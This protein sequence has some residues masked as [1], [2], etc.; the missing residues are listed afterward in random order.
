MCL[1]GKSAPNFTASAILP[2][3]DLLEDFSLSAHLAGAYGVLFFWPLSGALGSLSELL[4]YD[5]RACQLAALGAKLV[6]VLVG[7]VWREAFATPN[8]SSGDLAFPLVVDKT[9]G[10]AKAYDV[11]HDEAGTALRGTFLIDRSGVVRHQLVNDLPLG[12]NVDEAVRM[13]EALRFHEDRGEFCPADWRPPGRSQRRAG[14]RSS[15]FAYFA[16]ETV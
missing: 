13:L 1:V 16:I 2:Y 6:G 11:L 3:G 4:A 10:I 9:K 12:R 7:G 14:S 8:K 15:H 5:D